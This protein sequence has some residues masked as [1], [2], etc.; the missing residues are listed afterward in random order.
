MKN[1]CSAWHHTAWLLALLAIASAGC[2]AGEYQSRLDA[3]LG[4]IEKEMAEAKA[5]AELERRYASLHGAADI[6][7]TTVKLAVPKDFAGAFN[8]LN[9][10]Q[11]N[12]PDLKVAY[13]ATGK[14]EDTD[15]NVP[16]FLYVAVRPAKPTA[17]GKPLADALRQQVET[18][19]PGSSP[20]WEAKSCDTPQ[21]ATIDWRVARAAGE[22]D[23]GGQTLPGEMIVY[24][25]ESAGQQVVLVWRVPEALKKASDVDNLAPLV[26]GTLV[27]PA[28]EGG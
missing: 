10:P 4:A 27:M 22:Q 6:P 17:D 5:K 9:P 8:D 25:H 23:F 19:F 15:A 28:A 11:F 21:G 2:G 20:S 3:K 14:D 1:H 7:G 16:W 13:Q 12:L 26:A 18:A 24:L